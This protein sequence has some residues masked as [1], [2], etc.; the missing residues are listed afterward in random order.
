MHDLEVVAVPVLG[1][2]YGLKATA[3]R[4]VGGEEW[5]V[6]VNAAD[7][8]WWLVTIEDIE[9]PTRMQFDDVAQE[10]FAKLAILLGVE[11]SEVLDDFDEVVEWQRYMSDHIPPWMAD[12]IRG[13]T[14]EQVLE[15]RHNM[16]TVTEGEFMRAHVAGV[17]P[18]A[19]RN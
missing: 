11:W 15:W 1:A 7:S 3:V 18:L 2:L 5:F 12:K 14:V 16:G 13:A 19:G 17:D 4:R 10:M 9:R 6:L 8:P